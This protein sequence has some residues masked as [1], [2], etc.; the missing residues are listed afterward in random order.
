MR[1]LK[2]YFSLKYAGYAFR[3]QVSG[4]SV[5]Y[6]TDCFGERWMKTSRWAF[7]RVLKEGE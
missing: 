4:D 7:F 6:Y 5:Y 3:D 2:H 1:L